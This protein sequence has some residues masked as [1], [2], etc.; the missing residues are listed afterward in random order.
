MTKLQYLRARNKNKL[1]FEQLPVDVQRT[2]KRIPNK[3]DEWKAVWG[4]DC[5]EW[6]SD[7]PVRRGPDRLGMFNRER[8]FRIPEF[9]HRPPGIPQDLHEEYS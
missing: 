2:L 3:V 5:K 7:I 9:P 1:S 8:I 4:Y 6:H